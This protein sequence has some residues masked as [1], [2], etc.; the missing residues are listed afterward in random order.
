MLMGYHSVLWEKQVNGNT[1]EIK[2]GLLGVTALLAAA[3]LIS[4]GPDL[5]RFALL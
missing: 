1:Y 2:L 5:I 4:I 3:C